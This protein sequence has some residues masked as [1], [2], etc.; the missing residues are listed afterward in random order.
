MKKQELVKTE[1]L[2]NFPRKN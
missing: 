2:Q 1:D